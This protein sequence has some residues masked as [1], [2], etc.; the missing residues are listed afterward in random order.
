MNEQARFVAGLIAGVFATAFL[1]ISNKELLNHRALS[2]IGTEVLLTLHAAVTYA[3]YR[4]QHCC[5][6]VPKMNVPPYLLG[7]VAISPVFS[8]ELSLMTLKVASVS[9][10]QLSR[11]LSLPL[12]AAVDVMLYGKHRGA[13]EWLSLIMLGYGAVMGS[14]GDVTATPLA[15]FY[16]ALSVVCALVSSASTGHVLKTTG[17]PIND[18]LPTL[19]AYKLGLSLIML[20]GSPMV[21]GTGSVSSIA[22][23]L[24]SRV[25]LTNWYC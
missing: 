8:V 15:C 13:F 21:N 14:R 7:V 1:V 9:F 19:S 23:S 22:A 5:N 2:G 3:F 25:S 18:L 6:P 11:L 20:L 17:I 16:A 24:P 12:S 4:S 10:Q